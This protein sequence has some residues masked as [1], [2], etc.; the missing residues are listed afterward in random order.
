MASDPFVIKAL[1]ANQAIE[2]LNN[3]QNSNLINDQL[4]LKYC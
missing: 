1:S 4:L 2:V 3:L